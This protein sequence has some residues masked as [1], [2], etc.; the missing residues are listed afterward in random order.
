M[1]KSDL[2]KNTGQLLAQRESQVLICHTNESSHSTH[3]VKEA[4]GI[5]RMM[6]DF[7]ASWARGLLNNAT[8]IRGRLFCFQ[9]VL[10]GNSLTD[11]PRSIFY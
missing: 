7:D 10:P 2:V 9:L 3:T 4:Q 8:H 1:A 11:T 5:G 6:P